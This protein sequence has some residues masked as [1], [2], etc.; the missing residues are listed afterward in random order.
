MKTRSRKMRYFDKFKNPCLIESSLKESKLTTCLL[1]WLSMSVGNMVL[2]HPHFKVDLTFWKSR[3]LITLVNLR[4]K[5]RAQK[6]TS[7]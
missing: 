2:E 6:G 7:Y 1:L 4:S 3:K 5:T